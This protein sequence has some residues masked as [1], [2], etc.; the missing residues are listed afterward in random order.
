MVTWPGTADTDFDLEVVITG[1]GVTTG[2]LVLSVSVGPVLA[3][4]YLRRVRAAMRGCCPACG[5]ELTGLSEMRCPECGRTFTF[6]EVHSTA[7]ELR[8]GGGA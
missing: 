2:A 7:E 4:L 8:F 6:E 5:Y 1:I 3:V